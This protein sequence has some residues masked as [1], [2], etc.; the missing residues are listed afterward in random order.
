MD[1]KLGVL[2]KKVS[3]DYSIIGKRAVTGPLNC[4]TA[5][6]T[7]YVS[8]ASRQPVEQAKEGPIGKPTPPPY[9]KLLLACFVCP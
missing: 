9:R 7:S 2:S 6:Y 3:L 5:K 8:Q 4:L 1:S